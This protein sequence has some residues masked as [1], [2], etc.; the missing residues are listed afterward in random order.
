M[1]IVIFVLLLA[2]GI[3][4]FLKNKNYSSEAAIIKPLVTPKSSTSN[5]PEITTYQVPIL[6]YHYIRNSENES[7][8]GK[9]LSVSPANFENQI[10][11]LKENNYQTLRVADLADVH[12]KALSKSY[13]EKKK[14]IILTFDDGYQDAY[15]N[16]LPV[17]KKYKMTAT[18][19]IIR[20]YVGKSGYLNQS[21]IDEM[22]NLEMEIGSHTLSHPDLT[23]IDID[24]AK[25]Q[26]FE[27]KGKADSFCYPAGKYDSTTITLVQEAGY[28]AAVTTHFGIASEKS[29]ILELPRVR[30]EDVSGETLGD[31][32]SAAYEQ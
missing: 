1:L 5:Y 14:P 9:N 32:I 3:F 10:S 11:F 30:A 4:L 28:Q 16:A 31:K 12:K 20:N 6:M 2:G 7:E 24:E 17:L 19:Y 8:L 15:T 29:S 27:S 13:F 21:Q 18:F 22:A 26:I 25:N 23:K